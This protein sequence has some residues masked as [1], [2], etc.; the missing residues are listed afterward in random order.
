MRV[1]CSVSPVL[2][3]SSP[4]SLA[5]VS[6]ATKALLNIVAR[7]EDIGPGWTVIRLDSSVGKFDTNFFN[8]IT[9]LT[10]AAF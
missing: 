10:I 9:T 3:T 4:V 1:D 2:D 7:C 8:L 5:N 6:L